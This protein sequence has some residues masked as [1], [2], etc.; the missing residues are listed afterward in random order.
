MLKYTENACLLPWNTFG[1]DVKAHLLVEYTKEEDLPKIFKDSRVKGLPFWHIGKGSN[2][3]FSGDYAGVILHGSIRGIKV[4]SRM[5]DETLIEV[6]AGEVWDDVC[7]WCVKHQLYGAENLSAIPGEVG[8]AVVQNI[9]AYGAEFKDLCVAVSA[10]DVEQDK[11]VIIGAEQCQYD[12]RWSIFK[13]PE[14]KN[15]FVITGALLKLQ[16][17]TKHHIPEF[18]L[19]Y[20]NIAKALEG[21]EITLESVRETIV[22]IRNNKLPDP[23]VMGNAGSFFK[24]PIIPDRQFQALLAQYPDIPSY[25]AGSGYRKVPAGWLIEQSGLKGFQLG[26]A[27]VYEKQCLVLVNKDHATPQDIVQLCEHVIRTV[28][29]KFG[30]T[31]EPEVNI[32]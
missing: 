18:R 13:A 24:N 1:M 28:Q 32:L 19:S 27:A 29:S 20:G 3:L 7:D 22:S 26:G 12:Y 6:G 14:Y 25:E 9:G 4:I 31:I 15:R 8:A 2:L 30:I 17:P 21:K 11:Q 16:H 10:Y 23:K 5:D